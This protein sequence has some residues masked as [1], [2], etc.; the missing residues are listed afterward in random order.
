[1]GTSDEKTTRFVVID[2]SLFNLEEKEFRQQIP[3]E[4]PPRQTHE[5]TKQASAIIDAR[6]SP[7]ERVP[8]MPASGT[9][10]AAALAMIPKMELGGGAISD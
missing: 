9:F 1:M 2:P 8:A 5:C 10:G 4:R 3:R 7:D 6:S